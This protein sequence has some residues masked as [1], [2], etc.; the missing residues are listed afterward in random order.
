M[1][2]RAKVAK[3]LDEIMPQAIGQEDGLYRA[4]ERAVQAL[5]KAAQELVRVKGE[6]G[7]RIDFDKEAIPEALAV[8]VEHFSNHLRVF[9]VKLEDD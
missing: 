5:K 3:V 2:N 6:F 8:L 1:F 7:I 9:R 4:E